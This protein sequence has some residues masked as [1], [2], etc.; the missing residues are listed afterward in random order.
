M[1]VGHL[2][3]HSAAINSINWAPHCA[4]NICSAGED[5]RAVIW[6][7]GELPKAE[8]KMFLTYNAAGE[9][10]NAAWSALHP[11][12]LAITYKQQVQ[13]LHV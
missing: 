2:D 12:W 9:I 1:P 10:N 8:P 11:D 13:L 4:S 6:D 5:H 7:V 3:G